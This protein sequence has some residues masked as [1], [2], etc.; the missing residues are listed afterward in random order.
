MRPP[1]P[2]PPPPRDGAG[3]LMVRSDPSSLHSGE[4]RWT[5]TPQRFRFWKKLS[6]PHPCPDFVTWLITGHPF[7]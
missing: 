5:G 2:E 6:L 4:K 1:C 3:K 7:L